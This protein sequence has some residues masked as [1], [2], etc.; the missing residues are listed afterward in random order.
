MQA[1]VVEQVMP[2][3]EHRLLRPELGCGG[4]LHGVGHRRRLDR[5]GAKGLQLSARG[6]HVRESEMDVERVGQSV[7][8]FE[9]E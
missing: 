2:A 6:A 5:R 7:Q 3:G 1:A 8:H 4:W 9:V